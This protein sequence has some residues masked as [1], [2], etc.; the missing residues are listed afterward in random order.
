[1]TPDTAARRISGPSSHHPRTAPL[2]LDALG[3]G[4]GSVFAD[5]GCGPGDYA[6]DAAVRVGPAGAVLALDSWNR[7]LTELRSESARRGLDT[8]LPVRAD[9]TAPLPLVA[10]QV[11]ACLLALVLHMPGRMDGLGALLDEVR[12]VLRPGGRLGVL[13][14]AGHDGLPASHPARRLTPRWIAD[15]AQRHGLVH[16]ELV[17]MGRMWLAGFAAGG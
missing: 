14:H 10:H 13:E 8:L 17:D 5:L 1:M 3:L 7:A 16:L 11:D 12:R 9:V 15:Q 4:P 2:V 6:L